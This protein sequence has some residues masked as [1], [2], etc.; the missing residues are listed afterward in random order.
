MFYW[1]Q[2]GGRTKKKNGNEEGKERNKTGNVKFSATVK[3]MENFLKRKK[4]HITWDSC[5]NVL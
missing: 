4:F 5:L 3:D 2:K 1:R